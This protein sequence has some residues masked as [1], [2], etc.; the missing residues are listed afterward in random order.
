MPPIRIDFDLPDAHFVKIDEVEPG[1]TKAIKMLEAGEDSEDVSYHYGV[2]C[3]PGDDGGTVVKYESSSMGI[4][5][6]ED[7][8]RLPG[9]TSGRRIIEVRENQ[10]GS[11][12]IPTKWGEATLRITHYTAGN[13][14]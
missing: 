2:S 14:A 11:A 5:P 10:S 9:L 1:N 4:V 8:L 13:E 3:K 12:K 7:R 6:G